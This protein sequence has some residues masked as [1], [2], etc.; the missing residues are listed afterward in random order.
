MLSLFGSMERRRDVSHHRRIGPRCLPSRIA[1]ALELGELGEHEGDDL[2][3]DFRGGVEELVKPA[4]IPVHVRFVRQDV[5]AREPSRKSSQTSP[6]SV[7]S[8]QWPTFGHGC[9]S[10]RVGVWGWDL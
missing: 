6:S 10:A 4:L 3:G 8:Q 2:S 5:M 1:G 9:W 7:R